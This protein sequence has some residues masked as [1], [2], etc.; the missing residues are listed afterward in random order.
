MSRPVAVSRFT[1]IIAVLIVTLGIVRPVSAR[2]QAMSASAAADSVAVMQTLETML[3]AM[4]TKNADGLR[5]VFHDA[6][7]MTLLRPAPGGGMRVNVLSG[8]QFIT[9]ATAPANPVL[10]EPIRN[11]RMHLDGDLATVWAEYQVRRDGKVSHCG[12]DAFHL[13]RVSGAWKILTVADT[14]RQ[15]GCGGVW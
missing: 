15:Q 2:A 11:I 13:V 5:A 12:Y 9:A 6:V 10:D 7:R 1:S 14:F 4:R 3:G 8:E